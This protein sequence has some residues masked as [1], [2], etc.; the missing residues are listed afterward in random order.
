V[1]LSNRSVATPLLDKPQAMSLNGLFRPIVSSRST[2]P[3]P[4]SSTTPA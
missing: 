3:E 1:T 4:A 2:D